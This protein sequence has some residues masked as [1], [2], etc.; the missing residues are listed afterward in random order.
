MLKLIVIAVT[1][2][3]AYAQNLNYDVNNE[4]TIRVQVLR[5]HVSSTVEEP[6]PQFVV[7]TQEERLMDLYVAPTRFMASQEINIPEGAKIRV[8]ANVVLMPDGS[9]LLIA[10]EIEVGRMIY[11]V[12]DHRGNPIWEFFGF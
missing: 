7:E 8:T 9:D 10:R 1:A 6:H 5:A 2:L 3:G 4:I 12:R 11:V